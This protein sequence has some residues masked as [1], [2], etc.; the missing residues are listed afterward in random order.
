M[1]LSDQ[2]TGLP[3]PE[4]GGPVSLNFTDRQ[5]ELQGSE[6]TLPDVGCAAPKRALVPGL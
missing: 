4:R 6:E 1:G 5:L 2:A 3:D